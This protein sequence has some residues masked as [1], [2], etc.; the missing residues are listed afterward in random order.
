MEYN[1]V[2]HKHALRSNEVVFEID[3][4]H[5]C[6]KE[7]EVVDPAEPFN[8]MKMKI[9]RREVVAGNCN[10][11]FPPVETRKNDV[12]Y[13]R[14]RQVLMRR[15][16]RERFTLDP[17]LQE[18]EFIPGERIHVDLERGIGRITDAIFDPENEPLFLKLIK[19]SQEL[20]FKFILR[21]GEYV[22]RQFRNMEE[23]WNWVFWM[24]RIADGDSEHNSGPP[25]HKGCAASGPR[26]CRPIQNM[27]RLPSLNEILRTG[28]IFHKIRHPMTTGDFDALDAQFKGDPDWKGVDRRTGRFAMTPGMF[29]VQPQ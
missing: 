28:K 14:T 27:E 2:R 11:V 25:Q 1:E 7:E 22:E 5:Y 4:E 15:G 16:P 19:A 13:I 20:R 17:A 9:N 26:L 23:H 18:I 29:E 12:N 10:Q 24:R 8:P 6:I 21:P 3:N